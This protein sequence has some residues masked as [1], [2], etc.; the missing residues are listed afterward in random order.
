[1]KK[2]SYR[3]TDINKVNI[4]KLNKKAEN[5]KI[6]IGL[7]VAK[8]NQFACFMNQE[9]EALITIKWKHP[10]E[11]CDFLAL[12]KQ[13]HSSSIEIAME[14]S[15]S[16]GDPLRNLFLNNGIEVF[17]V[18]PKRSHDAAEVFDGVPSLHDAKSGMIIARLHLDG[19]SEPWPMPGE[20]ARGLTAAISTMDNL[21]NQ[22]LQNT[23]RLEAQMARHWPEIGKYIDLGSATFL[24]LLSRFGGPSKINEQPKRAYRLMKEVGKN[25]LKEEKI[26]QVINSASNT[27]GVEMTKAEEEE[28]SNLGAFT[29]DLRKQFN[30]AKQKV[31]R[32]SQ[33][34]NSVK[35]MSKVVGKATA[36]VLV[37]G[38]GEPLNYNS[39]A[40]WVKSLGMNLKEKSSGK[41]QG[42][43]KITKR[44]SGSARRWLYLAALRSIQSDPIVKAW[45]LKKVARDGGL[46]MKAII[47]V[48]RK[49]AKAL[50]HVAR[51]NAYDSR[52]LFDVTRLS[53]TC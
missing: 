29:Q 40:Q 26:E 48:M 3:A 9:R 7:D 2:R 11:T 53:V 38:G 20:H 44:G 6:A 12:I 28:L 17:K 5:Q 10:F 43:L 31:E 8:E 32:M 4:D 39:A 33:T 52:K 42:Q 24:E 14:P 1:M 37:S 27:I 46:K 19:I 16:Y 34:K 25:L 18:S 47:A 49:L 36:A 35:E 45:Y 21:H 15:G 22:F 41:H 23:N 50:W 13:M 51:G 30:K